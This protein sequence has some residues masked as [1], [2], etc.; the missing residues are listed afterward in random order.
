MRWERGVITVAR[1]IV[2]SGLCSGMAFACGGS[3]EDETAS[4]GPISVESLPGEL[5]DAYCNLLVPCC[6]DLGVTTDAASCESNIEQLFRASLSEANEANYDY[7]ADAAGAC[8]AGFRE[9]AASECGVFTEASSSIGKACDGVFVGK[10][11][12]GGACNSDIECAGSAAEDPECQ[13]QSDCTTNPDGSIDCGTGEAGVCVIERRGVAGDSCYWT[14]T[15][16]GS[17][18]SCS[19][20]GAIEETPDQSRCY[21]NDGLYCSNPGVCAERAALG[22]TCEGDEGC[23]D[24]LRC[25]FATSTCMEKATAG[26]ACTFSD[27]CADGLYCKND[28]CVAELAPGSTC[29]QFEDECQEGSSCENGTCS[30]PS[31]PGDLGLA[32]ACVLIS[33]GFPS[34]QP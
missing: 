33:G 31:D 6:Q 14:C 24:G 21:T 13:I 1:L 30:Q 18:R 29:V 15:E 17:S 20:S 26:Q 5:A 27:D 10:V 9:A 3:S 8:L 28:L 11:Q 23:D 22:G 19:G 32:F 7:D 12:P 25:D 16:D 4:T 2:I 34:Q